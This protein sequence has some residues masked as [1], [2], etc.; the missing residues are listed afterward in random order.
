MSDPVAPSLGASARA[1]LKWAGGIFM[2]RAVLQFLT[3]L[4]L[5]RLLT[6]S[7]Y[8][9]AALAQ[10]IIGVFSVA[11][12]GTF[13]AHALQAR[14]PADV[15]WQ[16]HFTAAVVGN[17][18]LTLVTL[19]V[20]WVLSITSHYAA[21]ALPL[22]VLSL[23]FIIEV[24]A[25]LRLRM[26][27]VA[28]DWRR[29]RLLALYGTFLSCL[30]GI[31]IALL[32]GGVWALVVQPIV[33]G[34]PA[35]FDLMLIAKWRHALAWS[36]D[37]YRTTLRFG[38]TRVVAGLT[39]NGRE[40][41]EQLVLAATYQLAT[42]GIFTRSLALATLVT[43]RVGAVVIESLYP[44]I[45]RAER[46]SAQFRRHAGLVMRAVAWTTVPA[47]VLLALT[48]SDV[49]TLVYG[50]KWSAVIPLV[51]LAVG[52]LG[53]AAIATAA[54]T[55]LLAHDEIKSC[56][57]VD[58]TSGLFGVV[59]AIW[60]VPV[61][62]QIYLAALVVHGL[63]MLVLASGL[64]LRSGGTDRGYLVAALLPAMI[65]SLIAACAVLT[66]RAS[67]GSSA[68][69][70]LRLV[71]EAALFGFVYLLVLRLGFERPLRE[72]VEVAPAGNQLSAMLALAPR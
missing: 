19:G 46:Q 5:V 14:N 34:L 40:L 23:V 64:L 27:Q 41:I 62:M 57:V 48:A 65:A 20:A 67:V 58:V 39:R 15:D 50:P 60:L 8:G 45:T 28:H 54:N 49:V 10:T 33:F 66:A 47:A 22:A 6:P 11:S 37:R 12:F 63:A 55:L 35:A 70:S 31:A 2:L 68:I 53:F 9:S 29:Y 24:P 72:L 4:V 51:P 16:A 36:W 30:T 21:A 69:M 61:G 42:L 71:T 7:D 1:S 26:L 59:L 38:V 25:T 3:M 13:V 17:A 44:V 32:G 18:A 52:A 56:L 43:G